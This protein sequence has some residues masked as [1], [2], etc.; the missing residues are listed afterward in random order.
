MP[1]QT[2]R[3]KHNPNPVQTSG[4]QNRFLW[5]LGGEWKEIYLKMVHKES[6][7]TP[8]NAMLH[9]AVSEHIYRK[10]YH[11]N[12]LP[13]PSWLQKIVMH[14]YRGTDFR[15]FRIRAGTMIAPKNPLPVLKPNVSLVTKQQ[16]RKNH[17]KTTSYQTRKETENHFP[18]STYRSFTYRMYIYISGI[19]IHTPYIF[20]PVHQNYIQRNRLTLSSKST[21]NRLCLQF[22]HWS[23]TKKHAPWFKSKYSIANT[24]DIV[25]KEAKI[26]FSPKVFLETLCGI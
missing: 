10:E 11:S 14:Q 19:Y 6:S 13:A 1:K 20:D 9:S 17:S 18:N 23:W 2:E 26:Q 22:L 5:M 16:E 8:L 3:S 15:S 7:Y 24:E 25:E 12:S 4:T 21:K